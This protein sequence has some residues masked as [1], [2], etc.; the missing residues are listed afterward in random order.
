MNYFVGHGQSVFAAKNTHNIYKHKDGKNI[1]RG[2]IIP[3]C[4]VKYYTTEN[5][6]KQFNFYYISRGDSRIFFNWGAQEGPQLKKRGQSC[7][8]FICRN[9]AR[10][11]H[12]EPGGLAA[13][14]AHCP[15]F[16]YLLF[17]Y[18]Y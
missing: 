14:L 8:V 12:W 15:V 4:S 9:Q 11:G 3:K 1:L 7:C 6:Y 5:S 10:P 2:P 16:I 17:I 13:D 18:F